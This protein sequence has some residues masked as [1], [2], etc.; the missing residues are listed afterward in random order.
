VSIG[1]SLADQGDIALGNVVGSNIFNVLF[2]LGVSALAAPLV[3]TGQ[4]VRL[5]VPLM[6]GISLLVLALSLDGTL[7][8][9]DGLLL[10]GGILLFTGYQVVQ[11]RASSSPASPT[12]KNSASPPPPDAVPVP[13]G[14]GLRGW[15]AGLLAVGGLALLVLGA[16]WLLQGAVAVAEADGLSELVI[17]LTIV[18][19]GT[20]LPELA[21]S[22]LAS[23]RGQRDIA[24]GNV[25][26]SNVFN[27][28]GVLGGSAL[29]AP[30]GISVT[31]G[32]LWVDLP[33][34][35]AVAFACLPLFWTGFRISR[36]E[37]ALF[38]GYYV[39]YTAY[40]VLTATQHPS[41]STFTT[42]M[43][44]FV[45]PLTVLTVGVLIAREWQHRSA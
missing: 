4:L 15:Q 36:W 3:V 2:I 34:M 7:G 32:V 16:R 29:I 33:V 28:L 9:G 19:G 45:I 23:L 24:V 22:V 35:L 43:A 14:P 12:T 25:V 17:G 38:V 8:R 30:G 42:A 1:S 10:F 20:S 18:A 40:L 27:L 21:T 31:P 37:G 6:V 5:D 39:A 11:G 26:G 13:G 44:G 41:I